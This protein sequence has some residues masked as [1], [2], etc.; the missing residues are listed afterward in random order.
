MAEIR[1]LWT[2]GID[3]LREKNESTVSDRAR[4]GRHQRDQQGARSNLSVR[5]RM[6]FIRNMVSGFAT[7]NRLSGRCLKSRGYRINGRR[8]RMHG[9]RVTAWAT[10]NNRQKK[11][12]EIYCSTPFPTLRMLEVPMPHVTGYPS[13]KVISAL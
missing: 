13:S 3:E 12:N 5:H 8:Q 10:V 9:E 11:T 2:S 4:L 1:R 6:C 7:R